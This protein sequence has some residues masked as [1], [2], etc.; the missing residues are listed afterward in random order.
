[1]I[2]EQKTLRK[3]KNVHDIETLLHSAG[4][5]QESLKVYKTDN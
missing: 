1:M 2:Q 5:H 4:G 3:Y